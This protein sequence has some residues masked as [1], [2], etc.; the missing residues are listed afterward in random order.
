MSWWSEALTQEALNFFMSWPITI[1]YLT[2]KIAREI[3]KVANERMDKYRL[4]LARILLFTAE[5]SD[6]L[7]VF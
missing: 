5:L 3:S 7:V 4:R 1:S 6:S 2:E